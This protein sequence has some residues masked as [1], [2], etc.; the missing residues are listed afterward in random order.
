MN[1]SPPPSVRPSVCFRATLLL[2]LELT[3]D[4]QF[5]L[6]DTP[7]R[8]TSTPSKPL[9][10]SDAYKCFFFCLLYGRC[11]FQLSLLKHTFLK[12]TNNVNV[13]SIWVRVFFFFSSAT[14]QENNDVGHF[15]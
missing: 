14:L 1:F 8:S 12:I 4:V 3:Y 5:E 13:Y 6:M 7:R 11:Y 10:W 9:V 2:V 15:N